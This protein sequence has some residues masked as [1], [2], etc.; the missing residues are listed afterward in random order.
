MFGSMEVTQRP[1]APVPVEKTRNTADTVPWAAF[2]VAFT[3]FPI[4][5]IAISEIMKP[6][7][8]GQQREET[9]AGTDGLSA[10]DIFARGAKN[11]ADNPLGWL[12]G[13][14]E[15]EMA[16]ARAEEAMA[17]A[18]QAAKEAAEQAAK[19]EEAKAAKAEEE[20]AIA[21]AA[22]AEEAAK[23]AA[24]KAEEEKAAKAAEEAAAAAE[25]EAES[26]E[27]TPVVAAEEEV[28]KAE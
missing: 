21:A 16:A 25:A 8:E 20:A 5:V 15:E 7:P 11:L 2:G 6:K 1:A 9:E 22:K 13:P 14:S 27:A 19:L 26:E 23:A 3:A 17:A 28:L 12:T 10:P 24:A 18:Q 4:S